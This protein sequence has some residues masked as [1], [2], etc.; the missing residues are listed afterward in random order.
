MGVALGI[1]SFSVF[2]G[3][4]VAI[5]RFR[6]PAKPY[7]ALACLWAGTFAIMLVLLW[8]AQAPPKVPAAIYGGILGASLTL[9]YLFF[10]VGIKHDSPSLSILRELQTRGPS[11]LAIGEVEVFARKRPF[12]SARLEQLISDGFVRRDAQGI[13]HAT[14][15]VTLIVRLNE[16]YRALTK[17]DS[18][19]G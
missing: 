1:L 15:K 14:G 6:V 8:L 4:H 2:F 5:W 17:Q 12:V 7:A 3:L 16:A 9:A 18:R 11:G 19:S 10:Y 13:L